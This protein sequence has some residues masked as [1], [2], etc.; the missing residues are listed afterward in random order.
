MDAVAHAPEPANHR[1]VP[2]TFRTFSL[3]LFPA[4]LLLACQVHSGIYGEDP[5]GVG[6]E[7]RF[8]KGNK[9][10]Y[11]YS[12]CTGSYSGSGHYSI[13]HDS[14]VF[15]FDSLDVYPSSCKI[16]GPL[17]NDTAI[18]VR[19]RVVDAE[20]FGFLLNCPVEVYADGRRLRR[21]LCDKG[22]CTGMVAPRQDSV[23]IRIAYL[24]FVP[25]TFGL[26][27]TGEYNVLVE[28]ERSRVQTNRLIKFT[29]DSLVLGR[30]EYP[31]HPSG[32]ARFP[33]EVER[34]RRKEQ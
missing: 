12:M 33:K 25:F 19:L 28:L 32:F 15:A 3:F 22:G 17:R 7:Y 18:I 14:I 1:L 24:N 2:M 26:K 11:R 34:Y 30:P 21:L 6:R 31:M 23:S 5:G 4:V 29:R 10:Y 8:E 20:N 16:K 27:G 13:R 9:V